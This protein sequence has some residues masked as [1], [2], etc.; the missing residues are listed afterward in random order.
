[1]A[2]ACSARSRAP[3][4]PAPACTTARAN[5][6]QSA[7]WPSSPVTP[8]LLAFLPMAGALQRVDHFRRHIFLVV[9]GENLGSVEDAAIGHRAHGDDALPFA[10]KVG[11]HA[12]ISDRHARAPVRH[13]EMDGGLGAFHD[14]AFFHEPADA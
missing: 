9:L 2:R 14:A 10:E 1:M 4:S 11:K 13:H 3:T 12:V 5:A 8:S 7:N 6:R